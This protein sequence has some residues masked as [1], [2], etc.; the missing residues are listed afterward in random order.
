[1]TAT[2]IAAWRALR[3]PVMAGTFR[4]GTGDETQSLSWSLPYIPSIAASAAAPTS[5]SAQP[6]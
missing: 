5:T 2:K 1:M 6:M 4:G 3:E